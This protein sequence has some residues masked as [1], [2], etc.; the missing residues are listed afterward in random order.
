MAEGNGPMFR[1]NSPLRLYTTSRRVSMK[2]LVTVL[3]AT[4][5]G[6]SKLAVDLAIRF[7]GEIING[8][9]MQM[10][11]GLPIITNQIPVEERAGIPH[12]LISCINIDQ[13]PWK[14]GQFQRSALKVIED[15]RA[16]GKLPILV[17]GTHY[18]TQSIVFHKQL[19]SGCNSDDENADGKYDEV[20]ENAKWPILQ[21]TAEELLH[22]LR[23]VD[24]VMAE[25][26]HPNEKRKIRRS[27]QI[28]LQ[29]GRRASD[30]YQEQKVELKRISATDD[31]FNP[32]S[33]FIP[34]EK[35]GHLRFDTILLW[36]HSNRSILQQRLDD[37]VDVMID[38]GLLAEAQHMFGHLKQKERE[39]VHIDRTTGVWVSI[40][41]K[42]LDPFISALS[43]GNFSSDHLQKLKKEC[44][45][46]VKSATRQYARSQIKWI[47]G[48]LWN[49]LEAA[50]ATDRLYILDSTEA[51]SWDS[52][53][54]LPAEEI[55]DAFLSE[56]S[57]PHP[58]EVSEIAKEVF[59][60]KKQNGQPST[61][62]IEIKRMA[63]EVCNARA[64]TEDQWK[65]HMKGR[66]HK[67]AVKRES[68]KKDREEYFKGIQEV[69]ENETP[70]P[71][72]I[73]SG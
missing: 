7:D 3:G 1:L 47:Q 15:I 34:T 49:T 5:T 23:E 41:L 60:M 10:Y 61:D 25:R 62:N 13:E 19:V 8:D 33:E 72:E 17:G 58:S 27:L 9:A 44:I 43:A 59:E 21:G 52:A 26:W 71:Q 57:R 53:V 69:P 40:G 36:V 4:G 68:R 14:V 30:I 39:G 66:K 6:K 20:V 18:Y 64:M 67:N 50:N 35:T 45:E 11:K 42:E 12:H 32:S 56:N 65:V 46:S 63:C 38:K 48:R 37:R 16:R 28:Y 54:R 31:D 29:T 22:A 55:V 24:P 2:P 51:K 73:K 70:Q